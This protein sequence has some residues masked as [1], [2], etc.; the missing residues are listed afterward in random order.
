M[1]SGNL[2]ERKEKS[3]RS[4]QALESEPWGTLRVSVSC[5]CENYCLAI[6]IDV[7]ALRNISSRPPALPNEEVSITMRDN[8]LCTTGLRQRYLVLQVFLTGALMVAGCH[9][10]GIL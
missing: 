3:N 1:N 8:R 10:K 4:T 9:R 6:A 2:F 7:E 5:G